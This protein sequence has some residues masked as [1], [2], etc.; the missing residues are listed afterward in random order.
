[1]KRSMITT[2]IT[3]LV[4]ASTAAADSFK[5]TKEYSDSE[6]SILS[7]ISTASL[8]DEECSVSSSEC[9]A[10]DDGDYYIETCASSLTADMGDLAYTLYYNGSTCAETPSA[11]QASPGYE[12]CAIVGDSESRT[13]NCD[14]PGFA[15]YKTCSD[16]TCTNCTTTQYS[17]TECYPSFLGYS[18]TFCGKTSEEDVCFSGDGTVKL[19]SGATKM[20]SELQVG[21]EVLTADANGAFS[22]AAVVA[23]PH[24]H[25]TKLATFMRVNTASGKSLKATKMHLLQQCDGSLSYA[26]ALTEGDCLRTV[27]GDEVVTALS[28]TKAEGIYTAVTTNEFLVVNGIVA[29]PFAVTHGLVNAYYNL[30]R[31]V[32]ASFPSVLKST[33]LLAAN[34]LLGGAFLTSGK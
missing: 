4:L 5:T 6:C 12:T 14:T 22:Y 1:M 23:M 27:D 2:F 20:L 11:A 30:H 24:L 15:T 33:F 10:D 34:A 7:L 31:T 32:A 18:K 17:T 8:G 13:L 16:T 9:T 19:A 29:S 25:N 3:A 21:E 28:M 26:G